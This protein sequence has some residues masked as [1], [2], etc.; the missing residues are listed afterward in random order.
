MTLSHLDWS[1]LSA[2][3]QEAGLSGSYDGSAHAIRPD[4][5]ATH[6]TRAYTV[7][8]D[9]WHFVWTYH[10]ILLDGWS[11]FLL[12]D[13][14]FGAYDALREGKTPLRAPRLPTSATSN[15]SSNKINNKPNSSGGNICTVSRRPRHWGSSSNLVERRQRQ[16]LHH[17]TA[18]PQRLPGG[19]APLVCEASTPHLSTVF[20]GAWAY[21]LSVYSGED[22]ILFGSTVSGRPTTLEGAES[23]VGLFINTLPTR[24]RI[25][26]QTSVI[27][28]LKRLQQE[29]VAVRNFEFSS[30]VQIHGWSAAPRASRSST[31]CSP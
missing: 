21:V 15:G 7:G 11:A 30:L 18:A 12:I 24:V 20:Q 3:E 9:R 1:H 8:A 2:A 26:P 22:D 19:L 25:T 31:R 6:A 14:V 23:M 16:R 10:H 17:L 27:D 13:E 5:S 4:Q 29:Q 28:W